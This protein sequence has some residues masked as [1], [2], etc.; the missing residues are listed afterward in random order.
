MGTWLET[1]SRQ[2]L[3][4]STFVCLKD[5]EKMLDVV[6]GCHAMIHAIN[7]SC[8]VHGGR[9]M[10]MEGNVAMIIHDQCHGSWYVVLCCQLGYPVVNSQMLGYYGSR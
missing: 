8:M 6:H 4:S 7:H 3:R 1:V 2:I 10:I 9:G 5:G